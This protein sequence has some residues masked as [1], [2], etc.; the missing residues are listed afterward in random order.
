MQA[1]GGGQQLLNVWRVDRH[2]ED[3][4]FAEHSKLDNRKLL[5]HGTNIA[6]DWLIMCFWHQSLAFSLS[7]TPSLCVLDNVMDDDVLV[8]LPGATVSSWH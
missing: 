2:S 7:T 8:D 1:T 5:W 6:G 4:R 3:A